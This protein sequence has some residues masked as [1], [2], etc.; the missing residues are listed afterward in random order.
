MRLEGSLNDGR[1]PKLFKHAINNVPGLADELRATFAP[2][3]YYRTR[4]GLLLPSSMERDPVVV[5]RTGP[6]VSHCMD[7]LGRK[8][9]LALYYKHMARPLRGSVF[10]RMTP[11]ITDGEM[12]DAASA[13][14]LAPG[15]IERN[16]FDLSDQFQYEY[17]PNAA[18]G[19]LAAA[20]RLGDQLAYLT[21][22]IPSDM[23]ESFRRDHP[24][25]AAEIEKFGRPDIF[26]TWINPMNQKA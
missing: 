13:N 25:R 8:L 26:R 24:V 11:T 9:T 14:M 10:V 23:W 20:I 7:I 21:F 19:F 17:T 5:V 12:L 6:I 4:T 1:L 22:A 2:R 16:R 15:P 18:N 3:P